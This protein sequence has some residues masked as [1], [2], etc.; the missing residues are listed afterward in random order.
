[1]GAAPR[2]HTPMP[3]GASRWTGRGRG[4]SGGGLGGLQVPRG[5]GR[6]PGGGR[7]APGSRTAVARAEAAERWR[8]RWGPTG[9]HAAGLG[10]SRLSVIRKQNGLRPGGV[11]VAG[12][13]AA[14][15]GRWL[16]AP[17]P[18]AERD[19]HSA[20][21]RPG[22]WRALGLGLDEPPA[23]AML[24]D[25]PAGLRQKTRKGLR[26]TQGRLR[27]RSARVTHKARG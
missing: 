7:G 16:P 2:S 14:S 27:R 17:P 4:V 26:K 1:M 5:G 3:V 23:L 21:R 20:N 9:G 12:R 24:A 11:Q 19:L 22:A 10:C 8:Q 25:V 6:R 13:G 18:W 15:G